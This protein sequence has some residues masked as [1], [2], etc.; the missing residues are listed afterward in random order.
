MIRVHFMEHNVLLIFS[1]KY[2]FTFE[3]KNKMDNLDKVKIYVIYVACNQKPF[4]P[5]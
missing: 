5:L 1:F 2:F 3:E 4:V